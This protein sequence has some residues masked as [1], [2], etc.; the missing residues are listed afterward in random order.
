[1]IAWGKLFDQLCL[2]SLRHQASH[3]STKMKF[4]F[5][6]HQGL[7]NFQAQFHLRDS[8]IP[9]QRPS[10]C[11]CIRRRKYLAI[12]FRTAREFFYLSRAINSPSASP[13]QLLNGSCQLLTDLLR[14]TLDTHSYIS[15][16]A[17]CNHPKLRQ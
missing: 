11:I 3:H 1:M 2:R 4:L 9:V 6:G 10:H 16:L 7:H 8:N 15:Q 12:V 14:R 17:P 5:G 13:L